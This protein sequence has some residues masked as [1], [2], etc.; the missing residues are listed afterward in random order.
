MHRKMDQ[1]QIKH[2]TNNHYRKLKKHIK[3]ISEDFDMEAI[4]QFRIAYKKLRAFL[5]M[6]SQD[7]ETTGEIKVS[8]KLKRSYNLSG[9]VRDLQLQQL[10]IREATKQELKKPQAYINLLKKEIE[11]LT[12]ELSEIFLEKPVTASKK[13][14]DASIPNELH[15]NSFRNFVQKKWA[16]IYAII[17]SR[18]FSDD[19]IHAIRKSLKDLFYN[20][21]INEGVEYEVLSQSIWKGKDEQYFNKLL[22]E[23]G[24]FQNKCT[25]IGLLKSYW[26][27]SFNTHNR[28][29]LE[30]IK[31]GWVKDKVR[32]KKMLLKELKANVIAQQPAAEI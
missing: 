21:K 17:V 11:K 1:E 28:V 18:H 16:A 12:P 26:L 3:K 29:L 6:I 10:K 9:F 23:L 24:S 32:M 2:I 22:E 5:R 20:L 7:H 19:N 14:T 31:K 27:N 13:K 25:A 8:K 4:H 30:G 15:L